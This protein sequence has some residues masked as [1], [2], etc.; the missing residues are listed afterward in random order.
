MMTKI[1][2]PVLAAACC[3]TGVAFAGNYDGFAVSVYARAQEVR[4]M[5]D[6]KRLDSLWK[7]ITAQVKIDKIYL[8]T[9]RD[10]I[11]VDEPT[12][13][14]A[15]KFF[16]SKGVAVAGGITYTM[17]ESNR[18]ET[19]CFTNPEH[20]K[21]AKE[22]AELTAR[23]FDEF[24]LDDFFFTN[25]KCSLCIKAKGT[26]SW[27]Q[28][29][30]ELMRKAAEE[31][32]V[33]P[34]KAVNPRVKVVIKFP[35]WYEHFQGLGFDLEHEPRIFDGIYTGTETRDPV[36]TDQH[37]QQYESFLIY[38]YFSNIKPGGNGGG[39]VDPG[40]M[41]YMDRYAEQLWL[42][43]FAK[44]PEITLFD[45][46]QL[47]RP[48]MTGDRAAWQAEKP[49]FD[50]DAMMQPI[51]QKGG[52]SILPTTIAR[53][54]G[55]TFETVSAFVGKLGTPVGV[56][57]YKPYH[58]SGEDFLQNFMGMIGVPMDLVPEF[59]TDAK[60]VFLTE[61]GRYDPDIVAKMK[62]HLESGKS[63]MITS[64]LLRALKGRG[65]EDIAE[66]ETLDRKSMVREFV[67]ARKSTGSA[68]ERMLF[69]QIAYRTNDSWE[70]ISGLDGEL[71]WPIL[72]QASYGTGSLFVLTIPDNFADLYNLPREVLDR[73]RQVLSADVDVRLLGR[74]QVALFPYDNATFIVES[75]LPESVDVQI[76]IDGARTSIKDVVGGEEIAGQVRSTPRLFGRHTAD[77]SMFSMNL[78]PHSYRVFR[79][80]AHP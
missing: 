13:E 26:R 34:A 32:I 22:L 67:V 1:L 31:L 68:K 51:P 39:W 18:Y 53:A 69:P 52:A 10:R 71:G 2:T 72:H 40:A 75:F 37:L 4:E 56:K 46:R 23:H 48:I 70:D 55:Y 77:V 36:R 79:Y 61:S 5:G 11:V 20:R 21:K 3:S 7:V 17:N 63:V 73:I 45:L 64:G 16:Q 49:S 50:F 24:I 44:A 41:F 80:S 33:N 27:T 15:K 6:R 47:S 30:L 29:R 25:C 43:L 60:M 74:A 78:K 59:P 76:A 35:N 12:I 38:R 14:A 58:S 28:Y 62:K 54:A 8:E 19:F 57:S 66:L 9:H 42:T 65:I